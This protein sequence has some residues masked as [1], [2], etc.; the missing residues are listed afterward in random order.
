M[1][2]TYSVVTQGKAVME[3]HVLG[4]LEVT[5][6]GRPVYIATARKPLQ[7]LA[8]LVS[9]AGRPTSVEWLVDAL[10]GEHPP[11]A[12]RR[13]V[14]QYAHRLRTALGGNSAKSGGSSPTATLI[15]PGTCFSDSSPWSAGAPGHR[16]QTGLGPADLGSAAARSWRG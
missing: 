6:E 8:A 9:R 13:N 16:N 12:A 3:Y 4:S 5:D 10:R 14:Q 1:V 11:T 2:H 15:Q 7:M